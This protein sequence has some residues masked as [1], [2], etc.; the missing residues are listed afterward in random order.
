MERKRE[1]KMN[2]QFTIEEIQVA[3]EH[4]QRCSNFLIIKEM[5]IKIASKYHFSPI[6]LGISTCMTTHYV[7]KAARK[8]EISRITGGGCISNCCGKQF[9]S[10]YKSYQCTYSITQQF[11]FQEYAKVQNDI[12]TKMLIRALIIMLKD[13]K[14]VYQQV[15]E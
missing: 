6:R 8:E 5:H 12:R 14:Q 2:K 9:S 7:G 10:S 15:I 3:L 11:H 1:K 4:M 13:W